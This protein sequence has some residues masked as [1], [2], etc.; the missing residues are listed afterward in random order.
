MTTKPT[1]TELLPQGAAIV[2]AVSGGADSL[3]LALHLAEL[4][5]RHSWTVH[6]AHCEHHLR[7]AEASADA[8]F[9]AEFARREEL[10]FA[11]LHVYKS[12]FAP[13]E[14]VEAELR[15]ERYAALREYATRVGAAAI[16]VGHSMTD[17]AETFL[18]MALRGS[19]PRGLGSMRE[20]AD[21][22]GTDLKLIR[23]L[24][25]MTREEI[26][27]GL[28]ARGI[29]W[30]EDSMNADPKYRRVR[31]RNEVIPLLR[32]MEPGAVKVLARSAFLC[33]EENEL[34]RASVRASRLPVACSAATW[35]LFDLR[36]VEAIVPSELR[37]HIGEAASLSAIGDLADRIARTDAPETSIPLNPGANAFVTGRWL[38]V[39]ESATDAVAILAEAMARLGRCLCATVPDAPIVPLHRD[40]GD[41][42]TLLAGF[43]GA[44]EIAARRV[45]TREWLASAERKAA[46][47]TNRQ[48]LLAPSLAEGDH[49][50]ARTMGRDEV[51]L[52]QGGRKTARDVLQEAGI[53]SCLRERVVAVCDAGRILWIPGVRRANVAMVGPDDAGAILLR[54]NSPP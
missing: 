39:H 43:S 40:I 20:C 11:H 9:V 15:E 41:E 23:P 51:L 36:D 37:V 48:A 34:L 5:A 26:R 52:T 54:W 13:G 38:L 14:S 24:L 47:A 46:L 33:A 17:A 4:A 42:E 35:T 22:P 19:G 8:R 45:S 21:V 1:W 10:P 12:D 27:A 28:K 53:P 3:Y 31:V 30:L 18:L 7:G 50:T 32:S 44:G 16:A 25:H 6:V 49:L 2:A 29:E